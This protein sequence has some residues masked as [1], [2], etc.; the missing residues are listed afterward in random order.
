MEHDP[1]KGK[2]HAVRCHKTRE[3][4]YGS[5]KDEKD[6]AN[7]EWGEIK[8]MTKDGYGFIQPSDECGGKQIFFH[9][10]DVDE[11]SECARYGWIH[12]KNSFPV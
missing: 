6:E 5:D 2:D 7:E 3:A 1:A 8:R 11:T 12:E 10:Q 9:R 4:D